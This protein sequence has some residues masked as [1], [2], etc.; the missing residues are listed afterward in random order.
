MNGHDIGETSTQ[1]KQQK[2]LQ[3]QQHNELQQADPNK[4]NQANPNNRIKYG[5]KPNYTKKQKWKKYKQIIK[6]NIETPKQ[7]FIAPETRNHLIA[8]ETRNHLH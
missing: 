7:H 2:V 1:N 4:P 5:K 3:H 8:L 6:Y